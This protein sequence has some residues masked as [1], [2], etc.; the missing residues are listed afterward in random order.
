[1]VNLNYA[2]AGQFISTE[3]KEPLRAILKGKRAA[4]T[5]PDCK[6]NGINSF[7][8]TKLGDM[9]VA[10][11][12]YTLPAPDS[13][14][15]D[16]EATDVTVKIPVLSKQ[17][18][19]DRMKVDAYER[20][21]IRFSTV[22]AMAA[23]R[24]VAELEDAQIFDG[25]TKNGS[26]YEVKGFF[27]GA[28]NAI[29]DSLDFSTFGKAVEAITNGKALAEEGNAPA[30][31]YT[32]FLNPAQYRKLESSFNASGG[33]EIEVAKRMLGPNGSIISTKALAPGTGLLCPVD[34]ARQYIEFLSPVAYKVDIGFDSRQPN[35]SALYGTVL[36]LTLPVIH[37]DVALVKYTGLV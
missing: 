10:T 33:W 29:T 18:K 16:V 37:Y 21:G 15:D 28:G 20:Q 8:Y 3:I 27:T 25:W 2:R 24:K 34:P 6:G 32:F 11:I 13:N 22:T 26:D 19:L 12:S 23:A 30:E 7:T 31:S 36:T 14:A 9:S 5:N 4:F 1:M 17:F 35:Y